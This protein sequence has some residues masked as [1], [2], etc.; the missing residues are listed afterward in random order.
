[1][2]TRAVKA[3]CLYNMGLDARKPVFWGLQQRRRPAC[4][5]T[6]SDQHLNWKVSYL[7]LV[8]VKFQ[9]SS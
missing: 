1:M 6:Q 5:S 8:H 7:N 9:F 2:E 4:A 3:G